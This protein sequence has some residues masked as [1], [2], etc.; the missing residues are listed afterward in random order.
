M[1]E[2]YE[3]RP[4]V[5]EFHQGLKTGLQIEERQYETAESLMPLIGMIS[6]QAVRLLQLRSV[7]RDAPETPA[8]KLVPFGMA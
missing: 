8:R 2:H 4:I 5:E 6:V 1:V 7:A 3:Q